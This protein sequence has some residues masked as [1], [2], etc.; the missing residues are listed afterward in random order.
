M[1]SL[2]HLFYTPTP[3]IVHEAAGHSPMIADADYAEYLK[4]YGKIA[5][6]AIS[7]SEDY[8]LYIAIRELSDIK[9]NLN[10]QIKILKNQKKN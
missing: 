6:K 8:D 2:E 1:R 9:E 7:S 3:D 4:Y 5:C 10:P